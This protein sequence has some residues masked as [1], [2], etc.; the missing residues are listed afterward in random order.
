MPSTDRDRP[1]VDL[2]A[3][4][5]DLGVEKLTHYFLIRS[6]DD[7]KPEWTRLEA[8]PKT[9]TGLVGETKVENDDQYRSVMYVD[10]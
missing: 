9:R 4:P 6:G 5:Y 10:E 1:P 3:A 8:P 2:A 7:G